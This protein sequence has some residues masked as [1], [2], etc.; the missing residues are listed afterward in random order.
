[1]CVEC[2]CCSSDTE[3]AEITIHS[4]NA[5]AD[6]VKRHLSGAVVNCTTDQQCSRRKRSPKRTKRRKIK[7]SY[8]CEICSQHFSHHK[9]LGA[10]KRVVHGTEVASVDRLRTCNQNRLPKMPDAVVN[11]CYSLRVRSSRKKVSDRYEKLEK[12]H[13]C[14]VCHRRFKISRD[15]KLH[16][17]IHSGEKPHVCD[18]CGKEFTTI[19]Q[20]RSHTRTH[21]Q[22]RD[23]ECS[24][25]AEKFVWLKSLKRHM[26]T[27]EVETESKSCS[28]CSESFDT[29]SE[30]KCHMSAA[31]GLEH[32]LLSFSSDKKV[33]G[34]WSD[35]RSECKVCGKSVVDM[36]KHMLTHSGEK[37]H[38]CILCGS[39]FGIAGT[40]TVHMRSHTG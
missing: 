27:H 39:C 20:L 10:H 35:T 32:S 22:V 17:R 6:S 19:S 9:S 11:S 15:L 16:S 18:D 5:T 7:K 24:Q 40:L 2:F 23:Y 4:A 12:P 28:V 1:M 30:M 26:R 34:R 13:E 29:P 3:D 25:C 21:T 31:H 38:Q 8:C 36:R 33:K 37:R 14:D